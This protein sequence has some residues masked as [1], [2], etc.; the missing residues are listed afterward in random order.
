[1]SST[2]KVRTED[3]AV[4]WGKRPGVRG[5]EETGGGEGQE[6][7]KGGWRHRRSL[8]RAAMIR[9]PR[10]SSTRRFLLMQMSPICRA[11]LFR[12][13]YCLRRVPVDVGYEILIL[14]VMH[15]SYLLLIISL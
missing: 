3:A 5:G 9:R 10:S 7:E 1:M 15:L 4:E 12:L 2:V 13:I 14:P 8:R 11:T 6:F